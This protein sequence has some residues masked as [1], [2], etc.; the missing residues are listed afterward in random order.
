MERQGMRRDSFIQIRLDE[1][2]SQPLTTV[3]G[4]FALGDSPAVNAS[5]WRSSLIEVE[6]EN[7]RLFNFRI[8]SRARR[9]HGHGVSEGGATVTPVPPF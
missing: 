9:E 3:R 5:R 1:R 4:L 8:P 7:E 6:I 2:G